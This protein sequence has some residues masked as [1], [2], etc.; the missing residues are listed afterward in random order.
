MGC[1]R[2]PALTI[3]DRAS[4]APLSLKANGRRKARMRS[5]VQSQNEKFPVATTHLI[6]MAI[7]AGLQKYR[8]FCDLVW[9]APY[10]PAIEPKR[11]FRRL[12][13]RLDSDV[14]QRFRAS[15]PHDGFAQCQEGRSIFEGQE[16]AA[17][18]KEKGANRGMADAPT[19]AARGCAHRGCHRR[20]E[21]AFRR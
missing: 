1:A 5:H 16:I 18:R 12:A 8:N 14:A 20:E 2:C 11:E 10:N 7:P 6:V 19:T 21:A 4:F 9:L 13:S 15:Y 3:C 17:Y